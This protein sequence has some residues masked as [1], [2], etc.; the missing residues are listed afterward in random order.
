[1]FS[2]TL[3]SKRGRESL[4]DISRNLVWRFVKG[5]RTIGPDQVGSQNWRFLPSLISWNE[6]DDLAHGGKEALMAKISLSCL[7]K[8]A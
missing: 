6:R 3:R 5:L 7:A 8:E 4:Q 1:V 2:S